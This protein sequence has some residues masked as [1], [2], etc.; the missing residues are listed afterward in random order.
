MKI[1][2][3]T[4]IIL[5]VCIVIYD[6]ALLTIIKRPIYEEKGCLPVSGYLFV[7]DK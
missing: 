3:H 5:Y 6:H 2:A 4:G 1:I 7:P